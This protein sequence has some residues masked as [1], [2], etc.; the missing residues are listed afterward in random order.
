MFKDK[1]DASTKGQDGLNCDEDLNTTENADNETIIIGRKVIAYFN[2]L[3]KHTSNEVRVTY[4]YC[5]PLST[6][7]MDYYD[8]NQVW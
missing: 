5:V 3:T 6:I 4:H 2:D 7:L 8:S 1:K